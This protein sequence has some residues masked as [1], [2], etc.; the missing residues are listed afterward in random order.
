M[1]HLTTP[2]NIRKNARSVASNLGDNRID[3]YIEEV[4]QRIVKPRIGHELFIDLLEWVNATD[5]TQF[6]KE[7]DTLMDGGYYNAVICGNTEKR[8]FK[9]LQT[10]IN[11]YV[12]AK[13]LKNNSLNVTRFGNVFKDDEHSSPIDPKI[14]FAAEK[15][16]LQV[17]DGYMSECID[18]LNVTKNITKFKRAGKQNNRFSLT[19]LH[20]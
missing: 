20:T 1:Q 7:Y 3:P 6:P 5:K 14:I 11:Y 4:E 2:D 18:Y 8:L 16:A 9:G 10:A 15:D 12:Y 19:V 17:A 13:I